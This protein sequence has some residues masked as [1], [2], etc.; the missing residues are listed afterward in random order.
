MRPNA[1]FTALKWKGTIGFEMCFAFCYHCFGT[2]A[3]QGTSSALFVAGPF[4]RSFA[5]RPLS[6]S[7]EAPTKSVDHN[8]VQMHPVEKR[9]P[10]CL[11]T[12]VFMD[13]MS[14]FLPFRCIRSEQ[15]KQQVPE[16][17]GVARKFF[18]L[19]KLDQQP[20]SR[21]GFA[22]SS[23]PTSGNHVEPISNLKMSQT[24]NCLN[25]FKDYSPS[26]IH[27][28][29]PFIILDLM[30]LL[31]KII[32]TEYRT[33]KKLYHVISNQRLAGWFQLHQANE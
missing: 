15:Q 4:P 18:V 21:A 29:Y 30:C 23:W 31:H 17:S 28:L 2:K 6:R 3:S 32:L 16:T 13:T 20:G 22:N 5:H 8:V 19:S 1:K 27:L 10:G 7:I 25:M 24:I 11:A 9:T 33:F 26:F 14:L 12:L